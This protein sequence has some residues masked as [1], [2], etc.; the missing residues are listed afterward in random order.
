MLACN[1][2]TALPQQPMETE[3]R[4]PLPRGWREPLLMGLVLGG[5]INRKTQSTARS[6]AAA[7]YDHVV[8]RHNQQPLDAK[9]T[10]RLMPA[11]LEAQVIQSSHIL[12]LGPKACRGRPVPYLVVVPGALRRTDR[13]EDLTTCPGP[14]CLGIGSETAS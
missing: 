1:T 11:H 12:E 7:C 4:L 3:L 10:E 2:C 8:A 9:H 13:R 5:L 6:M 14:A